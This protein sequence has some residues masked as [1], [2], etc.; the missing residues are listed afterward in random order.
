REKRGKKTF[1][2][3]GADQKSKVLSELYEEIA[4]KEPKLTEPPLPKDLSRG[5]RRTA[6]RAH[7]VAH[8]ER[9]VRNSI[10]V[11]QSE[12]EALG[13][14]RAQAIER[15]LL[16]DGELDSWRVLFSQEAKV[17]ADEGKVRLE[18]GFD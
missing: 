11:E 17:T 2:E 8:L 1:D 13:R 16:Q 5:E 6:K 3:L 4:G 9:E 18:L 14:Q 12:L 7:E 10:Q 15:A